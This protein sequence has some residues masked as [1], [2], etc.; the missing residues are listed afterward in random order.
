V[1]GRRGSTRSSYF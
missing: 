1:I